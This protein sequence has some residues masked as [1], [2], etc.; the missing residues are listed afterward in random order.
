MHFA[1]T[2][3]TKV[4]TSTAIVVRPGSLTLGT[5]GDGPGSYGIDEGL[6][7][8]FPVRSDGKGGVEVVEG[9]DLSEFARAKIKATEEELQEERAVVEGL[10]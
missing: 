3:T 7:F 4:S 5:Q 2:A 6:I 9:L 8:S 1:R 10:L